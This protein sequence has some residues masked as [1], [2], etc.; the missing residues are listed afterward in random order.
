M[1]GTIY[2]LYKFIWVDN[3]F[4]Y[5]SFIY[6]GSWWCVGGVLVGGVLGGVLVG[7]VLGGGRVDEVRVGVGLVGGLILVAE[8][9]PQYTLV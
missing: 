6:G 5:A 8:G 9:P 1:W 3:D 4:F 2:G 7:G